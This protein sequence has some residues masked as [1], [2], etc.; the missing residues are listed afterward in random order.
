MDWFSTIKFMN[1]IHSFV[2]IDTFFSSVPNT[3]MI[4]RIVLL[5]FLFSAC[6]SNDE[7]SDMNRWTDQCLALEGSLSAVN[8]ID[9]NFDNVDDL[10]VV[11]EKY[12]T[13]FTQTSHG[14]DLQENKR[15]LITPHTDADIDDLNNDKIPD[16][17]LTSYS[18][19]SLTVLM[20]MNNGEFREVA[21]LPLTGHGS[22]VRIADLD[23][24]SNKDIIATSN[25]S[26]QKVTVHVYLNKQSFEFELLKVLPTLL[27]T[28]RR[29]KIVNKNSDR[30][31]DLFL[32]TSFPEMSILINLP[33]QNS[34]DI[35]YWPE[36]FQFPFTS[37]YETGDFNGDGQL[38]LVANYSGFDLDYVLVHKGIP[39]ALFE[40]E[41]VKLNLET[42]TSLLEAKDLNFD[43]KDDLVGVES[44]TDA[45]L[46]NRIFCYYSKGNFIFSKPAIIEM[47]AD[48][49][50]FTVL[51][52]YLVC[53]LSNGNL[54]IRD[55]L[56][57]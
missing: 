17:I 41:S 13:V 53:A 7:E 24:D 35:R 16:V 26:G 40:E 32:R 29:M 22:R 25:G 3:F 45:S 27:D 20:G 8:K 49:Q 2:S 52:R 12:I 15:T 37:A 43:G 48:V 6:T 47:K 42:P 31:P 10:I 33:E 56:K 14:S 30:Y 28:D 18:S 46:S 39:S 23:M 5:L 9:T 4:K 55:L 11:T 21:V 38:D 54:E 51:D 57:K 1:N 19:N 50:Y 34:F 36:K 44:R